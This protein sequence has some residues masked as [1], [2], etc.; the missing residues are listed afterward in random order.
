MV[1]IR[2]T[3][4]SPVPAVLLLK[5]THGMRA[6]LTH[7]CSGSYRVS[8]Y[9]R[10][11]EQGGPSCSAAGSKA[12]GMH[13]D[14]CH[15]PWAQL[16]PH[17]WSHMEYIRNHLSLVL[18]VHEALCRLTVQ[19]TEGI[20][21]LIS[22]TFLLLLPITGRCLWRWGLGETSNLCLVLRSCDRA[23]KYR[24]CDSFQSLY[25]CAWCQ[26]VRAHVDSLPVE[27]MKRGWEWKNRNGKKNS[28][29]APYFCFL[30]FSHTNTHWL[31]LELLLSRT[32]I[33]QFNLFPSYSYPTWEHTGLCGAGKHGR[34]YA[35]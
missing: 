23:R 32:D 17:L 10:S 18:L 8:F 5:G 29:R 33:D 16:L 25:I 20:C 24:K 6:Q 28:W 21:L 22:G 35:G 7:F 15:L 9:L 2:I 1:D 13:G 4:W 30:F 12:V 3:C 11:T 26:S 34:R 14:L 27:V 31:T 19:H